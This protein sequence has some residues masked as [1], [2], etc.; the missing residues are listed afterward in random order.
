[1]TMAGETE[2]ARSDAVHPLL[3]QVAVVTG[4]GRGLGR[5]IARRLAARGARVSVAARTGNQVEETAGLIVQD[6]GSAQAFALDVADQQAVADMVA[7]T[8]RRFGPVDLLV[9]DAAIVTP[10]GRSWEVPAQDWWRL[11]EVN[12]YGTFLC[13]HAVLP[14]MT[15]RRRGRIVNLASTAGLQVIPHSSAYGTSKA[16]VIRLTEALAVEAE[17]YGVTVFAIDP[18]WVSTSMTAYAA[19]SAEGRRW[20][21][22]AAGVFGTEAHVAPER[23]ADLVVELASGRA[24]RLTGRY[25]RVHDDLED[26]IRRSE[27]IRDQDLYSMRLRD[28]VVR[29][30]G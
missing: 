25:L 28:E 29:H 15:G 27:Q 7:E 21:P 6:G 14:G 10:F 26:Q 30:D 19:H 23:A 20:M 4:A 11:L 22:W 5:V 18:G 12:L 8:E 2:D 3:D 13:A 24:D 16:A 17:E 9:N 1:V